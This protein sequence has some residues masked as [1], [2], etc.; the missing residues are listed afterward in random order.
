MADTLQGSDELYNLKHLE[1]RS[2]EQSSKYIVQ[3]LDFFDHR[4]PNGLHQCLVLELH[5]PTVTD[6]LAAKPRRYLDT[7]VVLRMSKQL[8]EAIKFIH[9]A[10]MIHGGNVN[11]YLP[12]SVFFYTH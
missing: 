8:L 1:R 11:F 12:F 5:G 3:L 7:K 4:G 9:G 10:G 6:V 2:H